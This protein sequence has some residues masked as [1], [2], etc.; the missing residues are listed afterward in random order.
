MAD[1][2]RMPLKVGTRVELPRAPALGLPPATGRVARWT[3]IMDPRMRG[4]HPIIFDDSGGTLM[5]HESG[6]RVLRAS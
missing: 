6:F 3:K 5:V 4:K 2:F 1:E